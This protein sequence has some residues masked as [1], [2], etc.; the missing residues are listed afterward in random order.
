MGALKNYFND[1]LCACAP[2]N[3]F[4]QDA[5]EHC[6]VCGNVELTYNP[7][8]DQKNIMEQYD[9]I[10]ESYRR[11][12]PTKELLVRTYVDSGLILNITV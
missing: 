3:Q 2:G 1:L 6:L 11:V 7:A 4:A 8:I 5:I 10:L 12:Q 9:S